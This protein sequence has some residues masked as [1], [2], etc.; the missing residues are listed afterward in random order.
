MQV[1]PKRSALM[2]RIRGKETGPERVLRKALWAAGLRYRLQYKTPGG[3]VDISFPGKKVAVFVDGC[4]WHGCPD[5]YVKPRSREEFWAKKLKANFERDRRQTRALVEGGWIVLRFWEHEVM[6][7]PESV[8][9][10]IAK[11]VEG[12]L[13]GSRDRA[14]LYEVTSV[15]SERAMEMR[16]RAWLLSDASGVKSKRKRTTRK[17]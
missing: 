2:S 5:H 1:D 15:Q 3:R 6:T 8:V 14:Q 7:R 9:E 16:S 17:W 13:Q 10:R 12:K 11:A 4:F